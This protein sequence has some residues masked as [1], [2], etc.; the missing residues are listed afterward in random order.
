MTKLQKMMLALLLL[1]A[2]PGALRAMDDKNPGEGSLAVGMTIG[3]PLTVL[4]KVVGKN[5]SSSTSA[6]PD[7]IGD[8]EDDN[9]L[10]FPE[11]IL[12]TPE[13]STVDTGAHNPTLANQNP[14]PNPTVPTSVVPPQASATPTPP[15]TP[16]TATVSLIPADQSAN[17]GSFTVGLPVTQPVPFEVVVNPLDKSTPDFTQVLLKKI[18]PLMT[19]T[20]LF[21]LAGIITAVIGLRYLYVS[22]VIKQVADL[23]A[24]RAQCDAT[25][26]AVLQGETDPDLVE[27]PLVA[28]VG[29]NEELQDK[30]DDAVAGY[31]IAL[32][33]LCH[34]L[35][36][37]NGQMADSVQEWQARKAVAVCQAIIDECQQVLVKKPTM[38]DTAI[39]KGSILAQ[40]LTTQVKSTA[41]TLARKFKRQDAKKA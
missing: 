18:K 32:Q 25:L 10:D 2:I 17:P 7:V 16:G 15:I 28:C 9:F 24:L 33:Q 6:T 12:D 36:A 19:K 22:S 34:E 39:K 35:C 4:P 40:A 20:G 23:Q 31:N 29:L 26:D 38:M 14:V 11:E 8:D 27:V 37:Q 1:G 41:T 5:P 13:V 3:L 30:L 21:G